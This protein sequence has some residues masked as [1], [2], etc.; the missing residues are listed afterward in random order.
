MSRLPSLSDRVK[1]IDLS[2]LTGLQVTSGK[3]SYGV[4]NGKTKF[5]K[6][7]LTDMWAAALFQRFITKKIIENS[8]QSAG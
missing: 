7:W 5:G 8:L 4:T 6:I 3:L 2:I 1:F